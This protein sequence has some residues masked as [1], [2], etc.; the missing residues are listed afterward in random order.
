ML[1]LQSRLSNWKAKTLSIGGRLT[2]LKS[3]LGASPLYNMSI[4]KVIQAVYMENANIDSHTVRKDKLA[5][6]L[7]ASFR[8]P[9]R[10]GAKQEQLSDLGSLLNSSGSLFV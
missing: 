9:V 10:G 7:D 1:Q 6:S 2:L 5:G 8:R 3:V 4:F